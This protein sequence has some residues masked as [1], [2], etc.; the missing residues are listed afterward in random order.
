MLESFPLC[1]LLFA[2]VLFSFHYVWY[3]VML[4]FFLF[5]FLLYQ[6]PKLVEGLPPL[7]DVACG[8]RHTIALTTTGDVYTFGYGGGAGWMNFWEKWKKG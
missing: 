2:V 7:K 6:T 8:E 1:L 5:S 4:M 3:F